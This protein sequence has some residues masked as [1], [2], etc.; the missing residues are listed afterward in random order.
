MSDMRGQ[1]REDSHGR[2]ER[3]SNKSMAFTKNIQNKSFELFKHQTRL[4]QRIK[5]N[6]TKAATGTAIKIQQQHAQIAS[7]PVSF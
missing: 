3:F 5:E 2:Y 4:Y 7:S 6:N 1:S